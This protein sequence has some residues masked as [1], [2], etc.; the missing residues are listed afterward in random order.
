M[1]SG[2][3]RWCDRRSQTGELGGDSCSDAEDQPGLGPLLDGGDK[4]THGFAQ[5]PGTRRM[6]YDED[7]A[8]VPLAPVAEA[9]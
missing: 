6:A 9:A 3:R 2:Q 8:P 7:S 4:P 5:M 1:S